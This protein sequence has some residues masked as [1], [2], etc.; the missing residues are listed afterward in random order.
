MALFSY[1]A[2]ITDTDTEKHS[3]EDWEVEE[4]EEEND[5]SGTR[6]LTSGA[7]TSTSTSRKAYTNTSTK[8]KG[9]GPRCF[10][11]SLLESSLFF[12]KT[13][14]PLCSGLYAESLGFVGPL[15]LSLSLCGLT[16]AFVVSLEDEFIEVIA[17]YWM[18][19]ISCEVVHKTALIFFY[20][21]TSMSYNH[22][23]DIPISPSLIIN[24]QVF[25]LPESDPNRTFYNPD[26][27]K[28]LIFEPF[29]TFRNVGLLFN[30][31]AGACFGPDT[32]KEEREKEALIE[33]GAT[34]DGGESEGSW[35]DVEGSKRDSFSTKQTTSVSS[36]L[37]AGAVV[38]P[39][40]PFVSL[41]F[42]LFFVA[43]QGSNEVVILYVNM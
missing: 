28:P 38:A 21:I 39:H 11:Y 2:D 25:V 34:T 40:L 29:R 30:T 31:W 22:N 35:R 6:S 12:S 36:T 26:E 33:I 7:S 9:T 19:L 20:H 27:S 13:V 17:L 43:Y 10:V 16:L 3:G 24:S 41:A 15:V 14:G 42:F 37:T 1:A 5:L 23:T 32:A 4:G 18:C 8:A